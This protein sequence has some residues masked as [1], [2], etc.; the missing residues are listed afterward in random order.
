MQFPAIPGAALAGATL[1]STASTTS[2]TDESNVEQIVHSAAVVSPLTYVPD[3]PELGGG[4][5]DRIMVQASDESFPVRNA[6]PV[7]VIGESLII[8][9]GYDP[10]D[11]DQLVFTLTPSQR[12]QLSSGLPVIVQYGTGVQPEIWDC[13]PLP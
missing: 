8:T 5:G 9:T 12:S 3:A 1:S 4:P 7:L 6:A 13:G 2:P 10:I 11:P